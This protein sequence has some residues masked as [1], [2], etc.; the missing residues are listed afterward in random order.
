M[1]H[2][3]STII[4]LQLDFEFVQGGVFELGRVRG[5]VDLLELADGHLGVNL[6]GGQLGVAEQLLD[7]AD[8]RAKKD[9]MGGVVRRE[10]SL[11]RRSYYEKSE[12]TTHSHIT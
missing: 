8:V 5:G 6:R 7:E 9:D 4:I 2:C 1:G 12:P 3:K 10:K 11:N